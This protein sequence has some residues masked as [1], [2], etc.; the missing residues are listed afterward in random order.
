MELNF[1]VTFIDMYLIKIEVFSKLISVC[2]SMN[3]K[4]THKNNLIGAWN[5]WSLTCFVTYIPTVSYSI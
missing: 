1:Q 5:T 3:A 4:A 2:E